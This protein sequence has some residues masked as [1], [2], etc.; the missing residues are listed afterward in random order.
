MAEGVNSYSLM[1]SI[2]K[3][4]LLNNNYYVLYCGWCV[5]YNE[6]HCLTTVVQICERANLIHLH[7]C[8]MQEVETYNLYHIN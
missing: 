8:K 1:L 5:S 6:R 7:K 4:D 2:A 3:K